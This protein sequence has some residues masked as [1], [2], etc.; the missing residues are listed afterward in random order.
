MI[1]PFKKKTAETRSSGSNYTAQL[2]GSRAEY[3]TGRSGLAEL[4]STVQSAVDFWSHGL[5]VADVKGTDIL[6]K[7]HLALAGR[8]LALRGECVFLIEEDGLTVCSDWDLST[9]AGRPRAYRVSI[10]D[11]GG[12]STRTALAGEVLH[13]T[14]GAD[15]NMPYS[16]QPPLRRS[17]LTAELLHHI[18]SALSE[19]YRDAPIG[20]AV[21]PFPE[22]DETDLNGLA[23]AF[24]AY[25]GKVQIRES[26]AVVAAGAPGP[27]TDWKPHDLT[28]DLQRAL[29]GESLV[30]ARG[31]IA[32]AFGLLPAMLNPAAVG[33]TIREGQ[34]H[35]CQYT[36]Q[37]IASL[38]G[39]EL[40]EKLGTTVELD[41]M[42]P[43]QSFDA[44]G[45]ARAAAT[46]VQ[47]LAQAE[48]AG[49]DPSL[50]LKLVDWEATL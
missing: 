27:A 12:G 49:V 32:M 2:I 4:T 26:V 39:E 34:R 36:L 38:M 11:V 9:R 1:W 30:A 41:V 42:R 7:R 46:I 19:V 43:L 40:S 8:A 18:E 5:A 6:S 23:R 20:S 31:S 28:P 17:G 25:R 29:V 21:V 10:P 22:T 15:V 35:A 16:G 3:I 14:I 45:R 33:T 47:A 44:G 13:F 48:E 37:P 50:A 24:R